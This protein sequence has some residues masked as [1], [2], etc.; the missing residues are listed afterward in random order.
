M[1][2]LKPSV[3]LVAVL[4]TL[5]LLPFSQASFAG[6]E[7][8]VKCP[9]GYQSSYNSNSHV[10]R[11]IKSSDQYANTLC[12]DIPF[13]VYKVRQGADKCA[14]PDVISLPVVGPIPTGLSSRL[15]NVKCM[16]PPGTTGWSVETDKLKSGGGKYYKDR[17]KRSDISYSWAVHR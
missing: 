7:R 5:V 10:L 14:T 11:C 6:P 1:K 4:S 13:N 17:C 12:P 8:G 2:N 16:A 3:S 15:R 9:S